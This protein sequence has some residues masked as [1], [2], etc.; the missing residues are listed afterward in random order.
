MHLSYASKIIERKLDITWV[1]LL[2]PGNIEEGLVRA[3]ADAGCSE[4]SLGFESGCDKFLQ[5]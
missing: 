3:M 2:Y 1:C 5:S 4:V